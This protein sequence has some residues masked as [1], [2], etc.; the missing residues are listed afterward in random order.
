MILKPNIIPHNS[1]FQQ[2][3]TIGSG[4]STAWSS[5]QG[6][7]SN[8]VS[9]TK[10][11][12][13]IWAIILVLTLISLLVV[14]SSTSSL[15]YKARMS[16]G[17]YLFKQ[18]AFI[19]MGLLAIYFLHRVNYTI[20]SRVAVWLFVISIPLLICTKLF[21]VSTNEASRWIKLPIINLTFQ[22][23][24]L[25]KL[26]LFMYVSRMLAK[27]QDIIKDF[28][29][30][31]IPIILPIT[32]ICFLIAM[33][34]FSTGALLFTSSL[35]LCFI[36]RIS[37]KH[38]GLVVAIGMVPVIIMI[39]AATKYYDKDKEELTDLPAVLSI[40]RIPTWISR[41][42]AFVYPSV[43]GNRNSD[44]QSIQAKIAVAQGGFIG[45]GPG[46]SSQKNFLPDSFSDFIYAI[47]L[48]EYGMLGGGFLVFLYLLFLFR[49]I[50][51]FKRCPYAFGAFLA[52]GLSFT[53]VIQALMN[54]AVAVSLFPVTG[55]TLPLISMGGTSFLFTCASLGIILSVAR[56][57]EVME[58]KDIPQPV[59]T[60]DNEIAVIKNQLSSNT[61]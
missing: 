7:S 23:S 32:S 8:I 33:D 54:M 55:V 56:N 40:G 27:K 34:N 53:L 15:A 45:K 2:S 1:A 19:L 11:D 39:Y 14:Y 50:R 37:L 26:A 42:Q 46:K 12:K 38:I 3:D 43:K 5:L 60:E 35:L 48:E 22:T 17:F 6:M 44:H 49:C 61:K 28:R 24:D 59:V 41:I 16:N 10:G 36:G 25:A 30:A 29:N 18:V 20:Y 57:V 58:G 4:T 21:G 51:I 13:V 31:F 47:V 9:K 52:L